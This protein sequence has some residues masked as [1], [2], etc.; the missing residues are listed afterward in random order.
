MQQTRL[1]RLPLALLLAFAFGLTALLAPSAQARSSIKIAIGDQNAAMFDDKNYQALKLKRT[2][3]FLPWNAMDTSDKWQLTRATQYVEAARRNGVSV[4]LHVSTDD[5]RLKKGKLPSVKQYRSAMKKMVPYF[6]SLGVKEF[7]VWNEANHASQPTYKN[8]KRAAQFFQEMYKAVNPKCKSCT[9]VALDVLDTGGVD[10]YQKRWY[11]ALSK[12]YRNRAKVVGIH[13]YGDVNRKRTTYTSKMIKT[14]RSYKR[15]T[16]FWFTETGGLVE[17][18]KSFKCSTSRASSRTKNVFSLAKKYKNSG[19]Q[20]V[21][22][23][24]WFGPGCGETRQDAGLV[25]PNGDPRKAY[26]TVK[27]ALR[28]Y[29][30]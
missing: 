2:R 18:G 26:F 25:G 8:P 9:I 22:L 17:F 4:L 15:N 19:V 23:Y 12:T 30:R 7:G 29:S 27:N 21:Y 6:R 16:K 1:P 28:S 13:N 14:S 3:Y 24:N 10:S 5:Y 11:R 20:R